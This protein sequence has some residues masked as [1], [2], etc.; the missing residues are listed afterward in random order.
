MIAKLYESEEIPLFDWLMP[1]AP[2]EDPNVLRRTLRSLIQQT[3]QAR[4]LVVSVDGQISLQLEEVLTA[5]GLNIEM[6][7]YPSWQ[8]TGLVLARGLLACRS[9]IVIRVDADDVSV[10]DRSRWQ[11]EQML[12]DPRLAVLGG[13]LEE[14]DSF[15]EDSISQKLRSVP[16]TTKAIKSASW[17]RNPINHPTV[18]MRRDMVISAGNYRSRLYFEDWDLWLRML[19]AGYILRNDNRIFVRAGVGPDHLFRR[20]GWRY[21]KAEASFLYGA[22]RS[23]LIPPYIV[24]CQCLVRFPLRLMPKIWLYSYMS[25]FMRRYG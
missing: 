3:L 9:E 13:Q 19:K 4:A 15:A 22:A 25:L 1:L 7:Q 14:V 2:W 5:S 18:A 10:P 16:L 21:L 24:L 11:V 8:G 17:W 6:H 20:H 23:Y 12:D